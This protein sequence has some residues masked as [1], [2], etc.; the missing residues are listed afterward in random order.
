MFV[1]VNHALIPSGHAPSITEIFGTSYMRT[2]NM[3]KNNQILHCDQ[4]AC[5]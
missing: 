3:R 1:G 5:E 4:I 2:H